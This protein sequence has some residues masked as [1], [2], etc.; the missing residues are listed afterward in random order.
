[1]Y[2]NYV[3]KLFH[4]I[5]NCFEATAENE[6]WALFDIHNYIPNEVRNGLSIKQLILKILE[7]IFLS[8]VLYGYET[9]PFSISYNLYL[10]AIS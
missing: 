8:A 1:L 3:T 10:V 9:W 7:N 6:V 4:Y 2:Y 5:R